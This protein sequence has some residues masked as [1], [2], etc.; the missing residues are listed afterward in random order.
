MAPQHKRANP[1]KAPVATKKAKVQEAEEPADAIALELA[2]I[3]AALS[4]SKHL[5]SCCDMLE[6]ALP[7]CIA[8]LASERHG[9]QSRVLELTTSALKGLEET[10]RADLHEAETGADSLRTQANVARSDFDVAQ[11]LADSKKAQSDAKGIEVGKLD[12][13]VKAV[14]K[15]IQDNAQKKD[16]LLA[17]KGKLEAEKEAFHSVVSD[18]WEPLKACQFS[19][20]SWRK[21]DKFVADLIE[22]L[23]PLSLEASL[24]EALQVAL[25][26]KL[27]Q[28]SHF[29]QKAFSCAEGAFDK[30]TTLLAERIVEAV[31]DEVACDKAVVALEA[32]LA[33]VLGRQ[34]KEDKEYVEFQN[35]W[36]DLETKAA[37]AKN[38]TKACD[39]EVQE[40]L[41]GV[42]TLKSKVEAALGISA[43]FATLLDPPKP[44]AQQP[45]EEAPEALE[46]SPVMMETVAEVAAAS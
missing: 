5:A 29:A 2:P 17:S 42:E 44:P 15:E 20:Q 33:E 40:A 46:S 11:Q 28:R 38:T 21:R 1:A 18:I 36:A 14:R 22:K 3:I 27:D 8:D 30:H 37:E 13:E 41:D 7:H 12:N 31:N 34:D 16:A 32:R 10:A 26:M 43:S 9:F 45:A 39:A 35:C 4:S 6:V 25:K 23:S 24:I 19:P